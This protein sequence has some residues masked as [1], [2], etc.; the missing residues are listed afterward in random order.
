[1]NAENGAY[2]VCVCVCLWRCAIQRWLK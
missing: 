1:M 2:M